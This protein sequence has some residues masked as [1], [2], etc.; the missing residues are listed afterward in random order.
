MWFYRENFVLLLQEIL[1]IDCTTVQSLAKS[2]QRTSWNAIPSQWDALLI[3]FWICSRK[4]SSHC[5]M[6]NTTDKFAV[7]LLNR[8]DRFYTIQNVRFT[9]ANAHHHTISACETSANQPTSQSAP[10]FTFDIYVWEF[11]FSI[12]LQF[13]D[14]DTQYT[15][16]SNNVN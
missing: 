5:E 14:K 15:P 12:Q 11:S 8:P 1:Q 7:D 16:Y 10:L 9:D 4:C 6:Q 3:Y 13:I 2:R